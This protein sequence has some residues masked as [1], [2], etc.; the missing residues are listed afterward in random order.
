MRTVTF[1]CLILLPGCRQQMTETFKLK[2][3]LPQTCCA[4]PRSKGRALGPSH[5][6][7]MCVRTWPAQNMTC[8]VFIFIR[9]W[10]KTLC[11]RKHQL[12]YLFCDLTQIGTLQQSTS[13]SIYGPNY[14]SAVF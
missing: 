14:R 1:I 11:R 2:T 9:A 4:T 12:R 13:S 5:L 7:K 10:W 6:N 3:E 8:H